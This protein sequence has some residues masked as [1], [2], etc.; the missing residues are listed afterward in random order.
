MKPLDPQSWKQAQELFHA[1]ADLPRERWR[2]QLEARG[3]DPD[4]VERVLAMLDAD[5]QPPPASG[6]VAALARDL[7][8]SR[9]GELPPDF[10]PYHFVEALGEGGMGAVYRAERT[11]VRNTVAIKILRDAW[12]SPQRRDRFLREQRL[13]ARL[14]HPNI[15]R[16]YDAGI[17]ETGTPWFVMEHVQGGHITAH[18]NEHSLEL[19][20]RLRLFA[21]VCE[22]VQ[23]AHRQLIVHRDLK[24]SNILV[25]SKGVVKLVD[26]GI[27]KQLEEGDASGAFRTRTHLRMFTLGYASPEQL[28][29][30]DDSIDTDVY[31]LGVVLFEL[32][33]GIPPFDADH[34]TTSEVEDRVINGRCE[35]P[36]VAAARPR[37]AGA[38][39]A[40]RARRADWADLDVL[41]A[42]AM[43]VD[44]QQRYRGTDAL[45]RD[46]QH[47]LGGEPLD[48]RP[49]GLGY[50][51]RKFV[52]RHWRPLGAIAGGLLT[53]IGL[54]TFFTVRLAIARDA[55]TAAAH[56]AERVQQ[57]SFDLFHGSD[58]GPP[59][60][61][62]V[63][64]LIDEGMLA[65]RSLDKEPAVQAQLFE[66]LG[67]IN[68]R[69]GRRPEAERLL[70]QSL[71]QRRHLFGPH[72]P[73]VAQGLIALGQLR[74]E[75]GRYDEAEAMLR[76]G[77]A[78]TQAHHP[79]QSLPLG[80][81]LVALAK[82]LEQ[83]GAYEKAI[84]ILEQA[85]PIFEAAAP[86]SGELS[87]CLGSLA[88]DH[89]YLKRYDT[90]RALNQRGIDIDRRLGG[91]RLPSLS[92]GLFNL[93]AIAAALDRHAE[94]ERLYREGLAITISYYGDGHVR[95]AYD[96]TMLARSVNRQGRPDEARILLD[97]ALAI[98]RRVLGEQH[99]STG[100]TFNELGS[101]AMT[102]GQPTLAIAHFT[103]AADIY[104][105]A[106]K[107]AKHPHRA[108]ALSNLGNAHLAA[109]SYRQA[110]TSLRE[111]L[112]V[113]AATAAADDPDAAVARQRLGRAL[114]RQNR[115]R[116]AQPE[117]L[118]AYQTLRKLGSGAR[119]VALDNAR[120]DLVAAYE[121]IGDHTR[122]AALRAEAE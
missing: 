71:E 83:R 46:V 32:L 21:Q 76:E 2:S 43:H 49:D 24:P 31:S 38:L 77:L 104:Q 36:S 100:T 113:F 58:A 30:D 75:E 101:V 17:S 47:F 14:E 60:D 108:V 110:E 121:L 4:L 59:Q 78:E 57:F 116:D 45:L 28:R 11:D 6:G 120:E 115:P 69:L 72:H 79:P 74:S 29:G 109:K 35:R 86:E 66:M 84:T 8:G 55:A 63:I 107:S 91:Q 82:V 41:C 85:L 5:A 97:R 87:D 89:F 48:A 12:L 62:K 27:S 65:A 102:L 111:A 20:A 13:L 73:E 92:A 50:R 96:Y 98:K 95:A 51:A 99:S 1:T 39:P 93:G 122:A 19:D 119:K 114:L 37:P 22:A 61:L 56:R 106:H 7:L 88:N 54:V 80:R 9:P 67:V 18:C 70:R 26:F 52:G 44:R 81:A 53:V 10:D 103:K 23:H 40:V 117:C 42:K 112:G 15:A 94:A 16:L 3:A 105:I 118:A 34:A 33:A 68:Q 90:S 64:T 25:T